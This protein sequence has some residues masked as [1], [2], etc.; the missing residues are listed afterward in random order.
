VWWV[1][2]EGLATKH[3]VIPSK[4]DLRFINLQVLKPVLRL[5]NLKLQRWRCSRRLECFKT[6]SQSYIR[7]WV[8]T[9]CKYAT[10]NLVHFEIFSSVLKKRSSLLQRWRCSCKVRE[11]GQ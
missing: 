10:S 11:L 6:R 5:L 8:T 9:R 3:Q 4:I 1:I 7:P 2:R